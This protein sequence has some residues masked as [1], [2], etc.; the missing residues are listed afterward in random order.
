[1][2]A[3]PPIT[4]AEQVLENQLVAQGYTPVAVTDEASTLAT[5]LITWAIKTSCVPNTLSA[6]SKTFPR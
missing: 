2:P 5:V 6:R 4:Q 1:M 3:A